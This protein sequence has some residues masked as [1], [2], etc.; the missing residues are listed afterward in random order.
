[1]SNTPIAFQHVTKRFRNTVALESVSF[2]I[3]GPCVVG[4]VGPNGS[5]KSTLLRLLVGAITPTRGEIR[6][7]G[8]N[9][10]DARLRATSVGYLAASDRMFPE[11]TLIENMVYRSQ[12][13]G[14]DRREAPSLAAT[15]LRDRG[16]YHLRDRKPGELSTGQRR[17]VCLL[18]VLMHKPRILLLDEPT[19]GIDM[20]AINQI[21][22]LMAELCADDCTIILATHHLEELVSLCD[23]TLALSDGQLVQHCE[24]RRLGATRE[25]VRAS[26]Q[27]LFQG[28][29]V[30]EPQLEIQST[31]SQGSECAELSCEAPVSAPRPESSALS[32]LRPSHSSPSR[33][34]ES[35]R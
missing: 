32:L 30:P 7:F 1:M 13:Y 10:V 14:V 3:P 28:K 33:S 12:F 19:T 2:S 27:A 20:V 29:V 9:P 22:A 24:T 11:L 5:G 25:H 26:L 6:V 31:S 23:R 16:L 18:S 15:L 17:Q 35:S 8:L 34:Q 4:L 21:Y